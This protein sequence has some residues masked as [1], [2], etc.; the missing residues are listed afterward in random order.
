MPE[1]LAWHQFHGGQ[2][3]W[4]PRV[5]PVPRS[6]FRNIIFPSTLAVLTPFTGGV[7]DSRRNEVTTLDRFMSGGLRRHPA[8]RL[9]RS[10]PP[11]TPDA[12]PP[13]PPGIAAAD[14]YATH[15][16]VLIALRT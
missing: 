9:S 7:Y 1:H 5:T 13:P 16:P 14:P 12:P 15:I 10:R 6:P 3:Q 8:M 2:G 11:R 4:F